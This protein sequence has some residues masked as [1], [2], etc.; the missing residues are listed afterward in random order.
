MITRVNGEQPFKCLKSTFS[1]AATTGGFTLQ[2]SVDKNTWTSYPDV[3]PA[4]ENLVVNHVTPYTWF[5]LLNN[6]DTAVEIIL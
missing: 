4:N 3:V 1:V 2:Y 6:A 5:R